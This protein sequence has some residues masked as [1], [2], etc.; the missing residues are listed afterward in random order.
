MTT[1]QQKKE[2][3]LALKG[4][5]FDNLVP[6]HL[7]ERIGQMFGG[8]DAST[9]AFAHKLANKLNWNVSFAMK[10][11]NEYKKFIYL[12]LISDFVVTPSRLID[13]VWHEHM[14]FTAGYRDFCNN[15]I[16]HQFD[17][18]P[19]LVPMD[20]QTGVFS[21]QYMDTLAL[22]KAEFN[23]DAPEAVWGKPKFDPAKIEGEF[24]SRK[25]K[26]VSSYV[27]SSDDDSILPLY[28][29][30]DASGDGGIHTSMPEF[31][32]GH[33][34]GAG[35]GGSWATDGNTPTGSEAPAVDSTTVSG[36]EGGTGGVGGGEGGG[37]SGGEGGGSCSGGS[38]SG[39]CGGGCGGG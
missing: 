32:G 36:S 26:V 37:V 38:C 5:H 21:A 10:A 22:Y 24:T 20:D 34:D 6:T 7:M 23:M 9:K 11:I 12:G 33:T 39:S 2:L 27:S 16:H 19:E 25:K 3:W 35:A 15:V 18:F 31:G 28:L 13:K 30:F 29:Y 1:N 8:T 14:L 17:H 4:Y